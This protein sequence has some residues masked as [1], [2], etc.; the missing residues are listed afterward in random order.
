MIINLNGWPGVGKLTTARELAKLVNGIVLDNH[1]ILNVGSAV[2]TEG[3]PEFYA[4]VRAVR[5]VAFDAIL[6]LPPSVPVILT[7]VV[8]RGGTSGFLEENWQSV[9]TL[10][11]ARN[12]DLFS[13]ILT[14]SALENARRVSSPDRG[15]AG[16]IQ[17][18]ASL[19]ELIETRT[20]FDDGATF[21]VR[22]D[23][24]D[25]SPMETA[26]LIQDWIRGTE[27]AK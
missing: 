13:V 21:R 20:L 3:S 10:A 14:C 27:L 16:K 23:N 19:V 4:V 17:N 6:R 5:S 1:T 25:L 15:L 2:A 11:K 9:V 26:A 8:A 18:P 22:I 24:S 12:C 7:N